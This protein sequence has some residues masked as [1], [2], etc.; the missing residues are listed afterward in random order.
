MVGCLVPYS[1]KPLDGIWLD[2][3]FRTNDS[4]NQRHHCPERNVT[5]D[6]RGNACFADNSQGNRSDIQ[7]QKDSFREALQRAQQNITE[8]DEPVA[9][10][11]ISRSYP[12][13]FEGDAAE[14]KRTVEAILHLGAINRAAMVAA[15]GKARQ[16]G[17]AGA[18]GIVFMAT[19]VFLVGMLFIR[20]LK[21]NLVQPL[22]EISSVMKAIRDG[23]SMRRCTGTNLPREIHRVFDELNEVLDKNTVQNLGRPQQT[24]PH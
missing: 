7:Q 4:G 13:A 14:L 15:D 10:Q 20:S 5:P 17:N 12:K 6:M 8:E 11:S 22:E 21:R 9:L 23:D 2:M 18:W 3:D 1:I 19:G 24:H 16:F